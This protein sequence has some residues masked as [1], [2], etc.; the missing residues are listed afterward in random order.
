MSPPEFMTMNCDYYVTWKKDKSWYEKYY[1]ELK[2]AK[3]WDMVLLKRKTKINRRLID[4]VG[5]KELNGTE[6]FY[7]FFEKPD[8]TFQSRNSIMAEFDISIK[9]AP[10][11]LNAWLVLEVDTSG[12]NTA[13]FRRTPFNWIKYDWNGTEHYK[14]CIVTDN[15]P[16]AKCRLVTFLWNI[17]K[18]PIKAQLHSLKLYTL[19][20]EGITEISQSKD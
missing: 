15:I 9:E 13:Y 6:E 19:E 3:Y 17:D 1:E 14:T 11:P 18:K 2:V 8:T 12:G 4:E 10:K 7:P 20:G 16:L 5:P